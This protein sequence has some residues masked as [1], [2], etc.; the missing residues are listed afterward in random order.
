MPEFYD[1][2]GISLVIVHTESGRKLFDNVSPAIDYQ[3][4]NR[5]EC[6]QPRL[7]SPQR[8]PNDRDLF[9]SDM[10][11]KGMD[12]CIEKYVEHDDVSIKKKIKKCLKRLLKIQ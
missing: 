9:W 1:R 6:L 3:L 5:R 10:Q 4:S 2:M 8:R 12:Y 7:I 11:E